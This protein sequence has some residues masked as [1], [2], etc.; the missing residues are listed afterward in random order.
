MVR[1]KNGSD[2]DAR[3]RAI[4]ADFDELQKDMRKLAES[5]TDAAS[6][7]VTEMA[8]SAQRV[9][10]DAAEQVEAYAEQGVDTVRGAIREQPLAAIALS[11]GAGALIGSLLRR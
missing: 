6:N 3:I 9:A 4:K 8:G 2:V 10:S 5:L 7:G 11:M 1:R